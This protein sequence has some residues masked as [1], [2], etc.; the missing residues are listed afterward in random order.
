M[1]RALLLTLLACLVAQI[2]AVPASG[3]TRLRAP[4]HYFGRED[5]RLCPSPACGGIW[6]KAVN[7]AAANCG[8]PRGHECYVTGLTRVGADPVTEGRLRALVTE[9]G[10]LVL[11]NMTN[12]DVQ[13]FPDLRA[14]RVAGVWRPA[15]TRRPKGS[16][17]LLRD[18]GVRCVT[19]PCFSVTATTLN[20]ARATTLSAIDLRSTGASRAAMRR[21]ERLVTGPGLRAAGT[22]ARA[23]DGGRTFVATQVYLPAG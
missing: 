3:E 23:A 5:P 14:L 6:L 21:A 15:S 19:T 12:A 18:N 17:R 22:I 8:R 7:G 1:A 10:S 4:I 2:G 16:V 13:G 20:T 11:G 9:A